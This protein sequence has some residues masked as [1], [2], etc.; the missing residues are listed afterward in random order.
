MKL[1]GEAVASPWIF[2]KGENVNITNT[3]SRYQTAN[4]DI[5]LLMASMETADMLNNVINIQSSGWEYELNA[6]GSV[7]LMKYVGENNEMVLPDLYTVNGINHIVKWRENGRLTIPATVTYIT[8]SDISAVNSCVTPI[9]ETGNMNYEVVDKKLVK[10]TYAGSNFIFSYSVL[11]ASAGTISVN[12][13]SSA[14]I[15]N[16]DFDKINLAVAPKYIIDGVEYTVLKIGNSAFSTDSNESDNYVV[17]GMIETIALPATVTEIGE[18][19]FK[20]YKENDNIPAQTALRRITGLD[21]VTTVGAEA[22]KNQP[23]IK[24]LYLP[25]ANII[26]EKA[27]IQMGSLEEITLSDELTVIPQKCFQSCDQLSSVNGDFTITDIG[28]KA[29]VYCYKLKN[30]KLTDAVTS[31]GASAFDNCNFS[32]DWSSLTGCTFGSNAT[33]LQKFGN[34][35]SSNYNVTP[36]NYYK[37]KMIP[38]AQSY[39]GWCDYSFG[40]SLDIG[41][42]GCTWCV[43]TA[44]YNAMNNANLT[45]K[46]ANDLVRSTNADIASLR[47]LDS[48]L[49]VGDDGLSYLNLHFSKYIP[50][51]SFDAINNIYSQLSQGNLL[52]LCGDGHATLCYGVNEDGELMIADS[53]PTKGMATKQ[54]VY[55][56]IRVGNVFNLLDPNFSYSVITK[57]T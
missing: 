54:S 12:G 25:K 53:S 2:N 13:L 47:V 31:I 1:R 22:F 5:A 36:C 34:V 37:Y 33:A 43:F 48:S 28:E 55:G 41:M 9:V 15:D 45:P 19:A 49:N 6:D 18:K 24:Q 39:S 51:N 35:L 42:N 38:Y 4:S 14:G 3:I 40:Q 23:Y 11:D 57:V 10:K 44:A 52:M 29:F 27:F 26:G 7:T 50:L 32:Y 17:N 8:D 21:N 56:E 20:V 46:E 16:T 30:F